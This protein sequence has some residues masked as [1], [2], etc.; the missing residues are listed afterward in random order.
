MSRFF[1]HIASNETD[2]AG[3]DDDAQ[4]HIEREEFVQ[5]SSVLPRWS[6]QETD[7]LRQLMER[8]DELKDFYQHFPNRAKGSVMRKRLKLPQ[9]KDEPDESTKENKKKKKW[10]GLGRIL[11]ERCH[12]C[13]RRDEACKGDGLQCDR[14]T[15]RC[16][17]CREI[18]D[19]AKKKK[20]R[21]P[22]M[23]R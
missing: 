19:L 4:E 9:N 18:S 22:N 16:R 3:L 23:V 5:P 11:T 17:S 1:A 6:T 21:K 20:K 2:G 14:C 10:S 7:L 8:G 13:A 15:A 12:D